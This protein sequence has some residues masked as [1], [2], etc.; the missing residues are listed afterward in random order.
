MHEVLVVGGGIAGLR[1]AVAAKRAGASVALVTQSHP[2]RSYSV[3]VQDGL[4]ASSGTEES[5]QSHIAETLA[6]GAG[7][8]D[9]AIVED[10]CRE[11]PGLVVELDRMGAPFNRRG[12]VIDRAQL[13]GTAEGARRLRGRHNRPGAHPNA[14][15]AGHRRRSPHVHRVGL[16]R[17]RCRER[18]VRGRRRVR[19]GHGRVGDDARRRRGAGDGRPEA[20]LRP[21][22]VVAPVRRGRHRRRLPRGRPA[23]RH[24]IRAVLLLRAEGPPPGPLAAALGG[25]GLDGERRR[26]AQR[27]AGAVGGRNAIPGHAVPGEGACGRGHAEGCGAGRARDVAPARRHR[28]RRQRRHVDAGA[29]RRGRVRGRRLPRRARARRQLPALVGVVRQAGGDCGGARSDAGR[30]LGAD[31]RGAPQGGRL[32]LRRAWGVREAR[33][34]PRSARNSPRSCTRRPA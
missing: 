28:R 30:R 1:A 11:A 14:V 26:D 20:G 21:Q 16:H 6:A 23:R 2:A 8:S 12:T 9:A 4:N 5:R 31:G 17:P 24:G 25:R 7:V 22:H 18:E 27:V 13:P 3:S 32:R 34:W 19:H 33:P 29:V 10:I 15:R